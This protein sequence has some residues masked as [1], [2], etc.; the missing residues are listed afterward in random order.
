MSSPGGFRNSVP[1]GV[2]PSGVLP[3]GVPSAPPSCWT[4]VGVPEADPAP[5]PMA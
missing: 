4:A 2:L 5:G 3:S 1:S